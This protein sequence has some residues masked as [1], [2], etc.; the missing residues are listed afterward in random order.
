MKKIVLVSMV[1]LTLFFALYFITGKNSF[2]YGVEGIIFVSFGIYGYWAIRN[3]QIRL[4]MVLLF[5]EIA[6]VAKWCLVGRLL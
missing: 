5:L 3:K 4:F 2:L 6:I 1:I